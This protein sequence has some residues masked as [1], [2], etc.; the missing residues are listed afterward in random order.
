MKTICFLLLSMLLCSCAGPQKLLERGN[1][2]KALQLS[3]NRLQR[4][5]LKEKNLDGLRQSARALAARDSAI[6]GDW[7]ASRMPELWPRVF[8]K[9]QVISRRQSRMAAVLEKL[10]QAGIYPEADTIP[11]EAL[12]EEAREK[13]AIYYYARAQEYVPAARSGNRQAARHAFSYLESCWQYLPGFRQSLALHREMQQ[14]GTT[15]IL[16][17]PVAGPWGLYQE[18]H[19]MNRLLQGLAFP[20][21]DGWQVVYLTAPDGQAIDYELEIYFDGLYVSGEHQEVHTCHATAEVENGFITR[22]E[23]SPKDSAFV[24]VKETQYIQVSATV[25]ATRQSKSAD[26]SLV[27]R[28]I[29]T[30]TGVETYRTALTGHDS[31][32]NE[33]TTVT[34]DER[35][36]DGQ[37]ASAVGTC[38]MFPS[39]WTMLDNAVDNLRW[40]LRRRLSMAFD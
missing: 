40:Q 37:C 17:R 14:L 18:N 4:G 7:V 23:W 19:Q 24:E 2:D 16:L 34:G 21:R 30:G 13:S 12:I 29:D 26:A 39:D 1:P 36:L 22:Q 20:M 9:A 15:H 10:A 31:W 35:A 32:S 38:W 27:L 11:V 28:L 8:E 5:R 25:T 6:L 3:L 33:Y